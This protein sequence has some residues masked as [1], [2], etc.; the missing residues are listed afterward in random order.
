MIGDEREEREIGD[1]IS[2]IQTEHPVKSCESH[3]FIKQ[4]VVKSLRIGESNL[5]MLRW[6]L[7]LNVA[8]FISIW[9]KGGNVGEIVTTVIAA[10]AKTAVGA[11]P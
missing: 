1:I 7:A 11:T 9:I 3:Q 8:V 5:K 6:S 10:V 2:G 4:G